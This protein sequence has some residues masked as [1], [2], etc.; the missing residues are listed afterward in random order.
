VNAHN[1]QPKTNLRCRRKGDKW[2]KKPTGN[3]RIWGDGGMCQGLYT[4][5]EL[6][7]E[8]QIVEQRHWNCEHQ[9]KCRQMGQKA[10]RYLTT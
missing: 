3:S 2:V 10:E 4:F 7:R 5:I 8:F 6:E 1:G 9:M